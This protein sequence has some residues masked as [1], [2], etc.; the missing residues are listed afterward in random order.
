MTISTDT[1][2]KWI[3]A[4]KSGKYRQATKMLRSPRG[5]CCL[6]VLCEVMEVPYDKIS[7]T[8]VFNE[9]EVHSERLPADLISESMEVV[10]MRVND[11]GGSFEQIA[12]LIENRDN[13]NWGA[14]RHI[15]RN[16][17]VNYPKMVDLIN[18]H[19]KEVD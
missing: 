19:T 13:I 9:E 1:Y 16:S 14:L 12:E 17:I 2:N 4:L 5:Y 15:F 3:T 8:Y 11:A 7:C 18:K 10:L 6:G